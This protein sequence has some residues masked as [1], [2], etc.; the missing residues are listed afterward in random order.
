M[1]WMK[2]ALHHEKL[3]LSDDAVLQMYRLMLTARRID[4]RMFALNRQGRVPF[5]VGS[6]GHEAI[7]VASVFALDREHDWLLP[8]YRDMGVALA[9]GTTPRDVFLAVFARKDDPMSGGR[10]LPNH[11]SDPAGRILT[12]SSAIATQYPHA[13]GIAQALK[14][15]GRPGVVVVYGGEG[16]T[17]EGDW[18]E[19]M[20]FA[21]VHRLPIVFVIENNQYAISVPSSE[22][23]AGS[24]S[25]RAE[26]YGMSG[27]LI[28]GN[29]PL[30][31][32]QAVKKAADEARRG[33][34]ASLIEAETYRYY[35]HT[36]DDDDR[37]YR[38]REEVEDWRRH[39]PVVTLKQYLI[40]ERFL[41]DADENR[42]ER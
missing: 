20:N 16:S 5:V 32:Y 17:S 11:W 6:S 9:W 18:H 33:L 31:V 26:G 12:Q 23:V 10:Q 22:G 24:I 21:G 29:D 30:V 42:I 38:S 4:D 37:L 3:G 34:G 25:K 35:A 36:S 15:D 14:L 27:Y 40:E 41:S 2:R 39:D 1:E 19:A 8:Y 28:D 7:Q 13:V